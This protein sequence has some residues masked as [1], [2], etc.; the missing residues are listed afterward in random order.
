MFLGDYILLGITPAANGTNFNKQG[1]KSNN[2]DVKFRNG[3]RNPNA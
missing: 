3:D 2:Y 1:L